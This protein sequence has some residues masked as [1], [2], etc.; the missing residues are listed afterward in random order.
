[1]KKQWMLSILAVVCGTFG[2]GGV[3]D[4]A[5]GSV[6]KNVRDD[7][8]LY[9]NLSDIRVSKHAELDFDRDIANLSAA[10]RRYQERLPLAKHPRLRSSIQRISDRQ[11]KY[12]GR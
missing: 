6:P 3:S 8:A 4:L 1:M 2:L 11:Y 12:S 5:L 10:E 7:T 9:Q